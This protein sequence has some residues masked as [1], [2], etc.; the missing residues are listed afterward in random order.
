MFPDTALSVA[1]LTAYLQ[2]LLTEDEQL[3]HIWI[4][5]EVKSANN[6]PSGLF[7]TL[8]DPDGSASIKCV[9]WRNLQAKLLQI[10]DRGE[11][12]LVLGSIRLYP[13]RGEYQLNCVQVLP[14][15][16]GLQEMRYRQ[17]RSRL[18]AEGLFDRARKRPLPPHPSTIAVVTSANAA[19]WGDIQR[20]LKQRY[21]GLLV[22]LSPATVQG[23]FAPE[24]IVAAIDRVE[25]DGRAQLLIL[26][27]GG[28]AV[29]DL[30][31]FDDERVVRAIACCSLPVIT[32]IGHQR[33]ESLADLAADV[34]VHTPTAAAELAVPDTRQLDSDHQQRKMALV[35]LLQRRLQQEAERLERLKTVLRQFPARSRQWQQARDRTQFLQ[36]KLAALDPQAVLSRGY[37]AARKTDGS[38]VRSSANVKLGEELNVQLARGRIK[39]RVTEI[40]ANEGE[41]EQE[42][43]R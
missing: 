1:G 19:A 39:V 33:D 5:G 3:Q 32:G 37:A 27:R 4:V 43:E 22:L 8:S 41:N 12:V 6:H 24:S 16:E 10:P 29:E 34:S 36:Q 23:Q 14:A 25:R 30:E 42:S 35:R 17:L 2:E 13:Q 21:P 15:G 38:L 11:Q 7:F 31:C 18:E 9:V 20:T 28:G 26:A 40:L